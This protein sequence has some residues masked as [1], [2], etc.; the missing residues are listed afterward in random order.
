MERLFSIDPIFISIHE[1]FGSPPNWTRPQGFETL[2]KIILEQQVSLASANAHFEKLKSR[3]SSFTPDE[4]ASKSVEDLREAQ[5]SRQKSSYLIGLSEAVLSGKL[6]LEELPDL[7]EIEIR[8]R[9]TSIKGIGKWSSDIYLLFCLQSKDVM[10]LGDIAV[11]KTIKELKEVEFEKIEE[12][13]NSWKPLRSLATFFLWHYYLR[14][15]KR[16]AEDYI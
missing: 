10:P 3:L 9:L 14:K 2:C 7:E 11:I 8:E 6:L 5:I 13:S 16:S 1:K 15:R 12:V 4:I